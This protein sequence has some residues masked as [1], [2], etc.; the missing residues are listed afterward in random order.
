MY[1]KK[2]ST[3]TISSINRDLGMHPPVDKG[4]YSS[5]LSPGSK[6]FSFGRRDKLRTTPLEGNANITIIK[7]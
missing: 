4:N 7:F 1:N 2:G 6:V 3:T 5:Y